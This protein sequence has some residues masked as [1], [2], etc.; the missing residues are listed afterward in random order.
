MDIDNHDIGSQSTR[1]DADE[2]GY[3]KVFEV[4]ACSVFIRVFRDS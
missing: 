3:D 1:R 4:S 2:R